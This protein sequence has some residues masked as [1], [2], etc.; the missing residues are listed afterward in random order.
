MPF[1]TVLRA[2]RGTFTGYSVAP[3][4]WPV[5]LPALPE[6][7]QI[8]RPTPKPPVVAAAKPPPLVPPLILHGKKPEPLTEL[9][10]APAAPSPAK[11]DS[12]LP[13]VT[14]P[15]A[16][17]KKVAKVEPPPSVSEVQAAPGG[18]SSEL[19]EQRS[20]DPGLDPSQPTARA[21]APAETGPA[22][23]ALQNPP[24]QAALPVAAPPAIVA[25]EGGIITGNLG[26]VILGAM[27]LA[28]AGVV[29]W[30]WKR[31]AVAAAHVSLITRSLDHEHR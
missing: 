15:I 6:G 13:P 9:V 22:S 1:V 19:S 24:A 3:V 12:P 5:D 8:A 28:G 27:C 16:A 4:P 17:E 2:Q 23:G 30:L 29:F 18:D 25:D 26:A 21:S 20:R 14:Q 11:L 10:P 7:L 31:R